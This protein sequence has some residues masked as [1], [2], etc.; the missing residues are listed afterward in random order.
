MYN[1]ALYNETDYLY[2]AATIVISPILARGY[3]LEVRDGSDDLVAFLENAFN[4]TLEE[5][6]NKPP[7][8][9]F[10]FPSD[11]SKVAN[12]TRANEIL[13]YKYGTATILGRFRLCIKDDKR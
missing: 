1:T 4:I 13:L 2:N 12:L 11:D 10:D 3:V 8:L 6:I 7:I 5:E 9:C